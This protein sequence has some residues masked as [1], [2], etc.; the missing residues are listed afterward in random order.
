MESFLAFSTF[1]CNADLFHVFLSFLFLLLLILFHYSCGVVAAELDGMPS[2]QRLLRIFLL[3]ARAFI[4]FLCCFPAL[5]EQ[6]KRAPVGNV[7]SGTLG[8]WTRTEKKK[9]R[10]FPTILRD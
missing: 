2:F 3:E 6:L 9:P 1:G 5:V 10:T 7:C 8:N 4:S